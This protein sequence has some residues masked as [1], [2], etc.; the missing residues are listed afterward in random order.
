MWRTI[1]IC[2]CVSRDRLNKTVFDEAVSEG[3]IYLL[4]K[5]NILLMFLLIQS[6]TYIEYHSIFMLSYSKH[7][8]VCFRHIGSPSVR[9]GLSCQGLSCR[10]C[11]PRSDRNN[12]RD[13]EL[14]GM[15][16]ATHHQGGRLNH[17]SKVPY[18]SNW[19]I[20]THPQVGKT[21]NSVASRFCINVHYFC[22][23][24]SRFKFM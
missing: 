5:F 18:R 4:Q 13:V 7:Q 9:Y 24:H 16:Q 22:L 3:S 15:V 19:E 10:D 14:H 6:V 20:N 12:N 11:R 1:S 21:S 8:I 23:L 2:M 17:P